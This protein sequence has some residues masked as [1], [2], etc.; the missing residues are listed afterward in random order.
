MNTQVKWIDNHTW[1]NEVY[2]DEEVRGWVLK[3]RGD[4]SRNFDVTE[5]AGSEL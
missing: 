5:Y 3:L 4:Y 2:F 1:E